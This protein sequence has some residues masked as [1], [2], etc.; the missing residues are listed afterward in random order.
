MSHF[1]E[2]AGKYTIFFEHGLCLVMSYILRHD[3][4]IY[5]KVG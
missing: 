5:P 3:Q 2:G 1:Y 4:D